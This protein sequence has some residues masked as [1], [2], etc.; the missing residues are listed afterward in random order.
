[1]DVI[2]TLHR[3]WIRTAAVREGL[4]IT[5]FGLE[6]GSC[7]EIQHTHTHKRSLLEAA[8]QQLLSHLW[9]H[10]HVRFRASAAMESCKRDS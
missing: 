9:L 1:M 8:E 10:P 7:E 2:I 5:H 4:Y 6:P 3:D